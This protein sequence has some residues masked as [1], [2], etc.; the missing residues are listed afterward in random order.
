MAQMEA[1]DI[2]KMEKYKKLVRTRTR[3]GWLMTALMLIVYFG[4]IYLVAYRKDFLAQ[5][6][7]GSVISYSIPI[8]VGVIVFTIVLTGIYVRRANNEFDRL[9]EEIKAG[10]Q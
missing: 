9:I 5:T 10:V 2:A 8:G 6:F 4:Y 7:P 3:Y 1:M